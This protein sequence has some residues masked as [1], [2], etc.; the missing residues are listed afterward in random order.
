M[1]LHDIIHSTSS[2]SSMNMPSAAP[3]NPISRTFYHASF[4]N[5]AREM[6]SADILFLFLVVIMAQW[7]NTLSTGALLA[8]VAS[9]LTGPP[10]D[11]LCSLP[12]LFPGILLPGDEVR[13][14]GR[15]PESRR[16]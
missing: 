16:V 4:R 5:K 15:I 13:D 11:Y 9:R 8:V 6:L 12:S 10:Q 14:P 7:L 3:C 2:F 1:G